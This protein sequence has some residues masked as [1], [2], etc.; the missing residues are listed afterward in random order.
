MEGGKRT[1]VLSS[2]N[3]AAFNSSEVEKLQSVNH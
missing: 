3:Y 2:I 1:R